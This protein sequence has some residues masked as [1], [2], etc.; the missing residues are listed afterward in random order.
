MKS[1][2]VFPSI[3]PTSSTTGHLPPPPP[4]LSPKKQFSMLDALPQDAEGKLTY[5]RQVYTAGPDNPRMAVFYGVQVSHSIP[6][7]NIGR[8]IARA[9]R[10]FI[11]DRD[12]ETILLHASLNSS[13]PPGMVGVI[14]LPFKSNVS[15]VPETGSTAR[16]IKHL[17][18]EEAAN[19]V[20]SNPK[21]PY[22]RIML[23]LLQE[24]YALD[25]TTNI[26]VVQPLQEPGKLPTFTRCPD[27]EKLSLSNE[28]WNIVKPNLLD[29]QPKLH[30]TPL[31]RVFLSIVGGVNDK[32][33]LSDI[34]VDLDKVRQKNLGLNRK[35]AN[36][37]KAKAPDFNDAIKKFQDGLQKTKI[38]PKEKPLST[39]PTIARSSK[40]AR[41]SAGISATVKQE[42]IQTELAH[43]GAE[44]STPKGL[45]R[46]SKFLPSA[47]KMKTKKSHEIM[48][49]EFSFRVDKSDD[50]SR[51]NEAADLLDKTALDPNNA[52][53]QHQLLEA[54]KGN[55]VGVKAHLLLGTKP[56][57]F[58]SGTTPLLTAMAH[59][60]FPAI[61]K[62]LNSDLDMQKLYNKETTVSTAIAQ[63]HKAPANTDAGLEI[64]AEYLHIIRKLVAKGA[65]LSDPNL[66][67]N[68][69]DLQKCF[70]ASPRADK[71]A[72]AV[73]SSAS[74]VTT[75]YIPLDT[76]P[77][78]FAKRVRRDATLSSSTTPPAPGY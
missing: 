73:S 13:I 56:D 55:F 33:E 64:R 68:D 30:T 28:L 62:I 39:D 60:Y 36:E 8:R 42:F 69:P 47:L 44:K 21:D 12:V 51:V 78:T 38:E 53:F 41:Q 4:R 23:A 10:D 37:L 17:R 49:D 74:P 61:Y 27:L 31:E 54:A 67:Q 5:L 22:E 2:T 9:H 72:T 77:S 76:A 19:F 16:T 6:D 45:K 20:I 70:A 50:A 11:G 35:I 7:N 46:L 40:Y 48:E 75:V 14:F 58:L 1:T 34:V 24:L 65:T 26:P 63:F 43:Y 66:L 29:S 52:Q 32:N 15:A 71:S 3:A 25:G 18:A 57:F 59:N